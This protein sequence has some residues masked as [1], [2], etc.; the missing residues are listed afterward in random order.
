MPHPYQ[1]FK[2]LLEEYRIEIPIL[3]RDYAQGRSNEKS[4]RNSFVKHLTKALVHNTPLHLDFVYG[5]LRENSNVLIPLDGQQ[6]LTTLW[7]L[8]WFLAVKE[9]RLDEVNSL[10]GKFCY[11]ARAAAMDFCE[12]L[13]TENFENV[14]LT[15]VK[16]FLIDQPW[17]D[18]DWMD[19]P[20]V[21]GMLT[22][23]DAFGQTADLLRPEVQ[24]SQ[25]WE[26]QLFT[27]SFT[28][29]DNFGMSDDLYIRMNAR[30]E[31][32]TD[33]EVFKSQFYITTQQH[34]QLKTIKERM[35]KEWVEYLWVYRDPKTYTTDEAFRHLLYFVNRVNYFST[36]EREDEK[37]V[38]DFLDADYIGETYGKGQ[39]ANVDYLMFVLDALPFLQSIE[40]PCLLS[41][42]KSFQSV[43][44]EVIVDKT[45]A[46][47]HYILLHAALIY[48]RAHPDVEATDPK[49]LYFL[50]ITRNLI[51]NT[52][53]NSPRTWSRSIPSL[54]AIAQQD[55]P[56]AALCDE[57]LTITG[58]RASQIIEERFKAQLLALH[59]EYKADL[60]KMEDHPVLVGFL[61]NL[62][63]ASASVNDLPQIDVATLDFARTKRVFEAYCR[64]YEGHPEFENVWG[65]LLLSDLYEETE[66]RVNWHEEGKQQERYTKHISI[67]Q[68]AARWVDYGTDDNLE[69]FLIADEKANVL[70]LAAENE[71]ELCRVKSAKEQ[72]YLLY[73]I[74]RR[75]MRKGVKSFFAKGYRFGWLLEN[76][77]KQTIFLE[78]DGKPLMYQSYLKYFQYN[79]GIFT[80]RSTPPE[81]EV[82]NKRREFLPRLLDWAKG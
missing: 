64:I 67:F 68:L 50:R 20:T 11:E 7:L 70:R 66:W 8:H 31:K 21:E 76:G 4:V 62:L 38:P 17:F 72:L 34:P 65:D 24:L 75:L 48:K 79:R 16:A 30:G 81:R 35:E 27:F 46:V 77:N 6:R 39:E 74:T 19:N 60:H 73:V 42:S 13:L 56:Y 26:E 33:F 59:P 82:A 47:A 22:M 44:K 49:L 14:P 43:L 57:S 15:D 71:G 40:F 32:L 9:G 36:S 18:L 58:F 23:L 12:R 3:Q 28:P 51:V 2:S 29:I 63:L 80:E 61:R 78:A 25:L 1:S 5:D 41:E 37:K 69:E 55:D 54:E 10:L 45:N 52:K 53:D